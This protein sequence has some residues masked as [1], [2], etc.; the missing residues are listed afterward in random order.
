VEVSAGSDATVGAF[1]DGDHV[2]VIYPPHRELRA[3]PSWEVLENIRVEAA[4][5]S[6]GALDE[7]I[8]Q[9][10]GGHVASISVGPAELPAALWTQE[11]F[12]PWYQVVIWSGGL[13]AMTS[14]RVRIWGDPCWSAGMSAL[15]ACIADSAI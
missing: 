4:L 3:W 6:Q 1:L 8:T 7:Q 2:E 5:R 12:P 9:A 14:A 10:L 15:S 13:Q 11:R